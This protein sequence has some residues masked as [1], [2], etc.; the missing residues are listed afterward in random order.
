MSNIKHAPNKHFLLL[1]MIYIISGVFAFFLY[2]TLPNENPILLKV[3]IVHFAVTIFIFCFSF[4]YKT[5]NVFDLH[6]SLMPIGLGAFFVFDGWHIGNDPLR[7]NLSLILVTLWGLRLSVNWLKWWP[8]LDHEDWR[9]D[10]MKKQS[11]KYYWVMSFLGIHLFS[12]ILI[13]LVSL[14]LYV[15]ITKL[16][17][18]NIIVD[19]IISIVAL[20]AIIIEF[21]SDQQLFNFVNKNRVKGAIIKEGL[22]KY[23]R[24]PNYFGEVLFWWA[25][26]LMAVIGNPQYWWTGIGA[27]LITLMFQFISIPMM[28]KRSLERRPEYEKVIKMTSRWI[29]WF[30]KKG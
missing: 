20:S 1:I 28:E 6:W 5:S 12:A 4:Y 25:I 17:S 9:F 23:S 7:I 11:G 10:D 26:Y 18:S 14:P 30:P 29:P 27:F 2:D 24:H 13:F 16:S 21:I 19:I 8:G 3:G 22:W 15:I